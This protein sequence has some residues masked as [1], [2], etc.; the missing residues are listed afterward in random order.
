MV[1]AADGQP[2]FVVLARQSPLAT[3]TGV[4]LA[5]VQEFNGALA[6]WEEN[7]DRRPDHALQYGFAFDVYRVMA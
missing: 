2:V 4:D 1:A 5:L 3:D 7:S 6:H